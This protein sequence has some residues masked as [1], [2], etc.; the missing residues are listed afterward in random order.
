MRDLILAVRM[1]RKNLGFSL[2][3]IV[4]LALGIGANTAIFSVVKA[5]LLN[6]L[7]YYDP[8]RLVA[9]AEAEP[10]TIRPVTVDFTT[11]FDLRARSRSFESMSLYRG[12]R[13]ALVGQGDP[14]LVNG[15]RVG[16][17]Y[18]DTLGV[19][20]QLGRKFLPEDD[21]AD[22]WN[23]ILIISNG[24]WTRQFG[25][26]PNIVGRAV[27]LNE[28]TFTVAG[29]LPADFRPVPLGQSDDAKDIFAP[30]G[31]ELGKPS[32]CRGCRHLRLIAR[33]KAGVEA[34][35][36]NAE[37]NTILAGIVREHSDAYRS[38]VKV[39]LTPL[40]QQMFGQVR[41]A[42]WVLLG[43]VG[44]V[45]LIAC[46]NVA[47][48]LLARASGRAKEIALRT[49]LG[50]GRGRLIRQML[51]E[52]LVLALAGGIGGALLATLATSLVASVAPREIPRIGEV[53]VDVAVLLFGL[54]ASLLAG[55]LFG[56]APALRASRADL[57]SALADA[58][59]STGGRRTQ[60]LRNVLV[61]AEFA[62]A[63]VL[64]VGA[65][66]LG[67]SFVRLMNVDPG[68][69]P[70]NLLTL[71]TYLYGQ[72]YVQNEA[73]LN[74]VSQVFDRL[75]ATPGIESVAMV[76]TLPL[77]S[78]DRTLLHIQDQPL[79]NQNEAPSVDRYSITP[80]YF[81]V[82][83]IPLKRGRAFTGQD[84]E[85]APLLA[86]VS[87]SCA[88]RL[89]P[90][91]SA[92]GKHIQMGGRDDTKPWMTIVGVVG[93]VRQY[94]LDRAP[95]MEAY[96]PQAQNLTFSYMAV[97]RTAGDPRRMEG[98]MRDAF[99]AVDKTQ[100]VFDVAPMDTYLAASLAERSF[101]LALLALFGALALALA[102]IGIYG[103]ISYTVSFRTREIGIRMALGA[104]WSDVL[105]MVLRQGL[106]LAAAGLAT[107][108]AASLGLTRFLSSLLYEVHPTDIATTLG[109]A[110][111]LA[112]VALAG[113]YVPARRAAN[114]DPMVA[115]RFE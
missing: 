52:S 64:V 57:T 99:M 35:A 96:L 98:A 110:V 51:T 24:L 2:V 9:I 66:L 83:S 13:S 48:L 25:R 36:A 90:K 107:G 105:G 22:R 4:T 43:A 23:H 26:D 46:A 97:A 111:L 32:A 17:D 86:I 103:V 33:L 16:Y 12:W 115:L 62:L 49:A 14:V 15:L 84:R 55:V 73:S 8:D 81:R 65:G 77:T 28:S 82:M 42:L 61:T 5:V 37:L 1:L 63:F 21:R 41:T 53:K 7:P 68:F 106:T 113:S 47:N 20:M 75:R 58:G 112:L 45:L 19:K 87:E 89:F 54:A 56:L 76:S 18:F 72:R 31:Y 27:Q 92:I 3:A 38:D 104:K 39:A 93:D 102:A 44:F 11:T 85:G 79:A 95:N 94:G 80:D 71:N 78:F 60:S 6:Q 67:K 70:H 109:V 114:V 59:R 34:G 30:L 29:V 91:E 69:D 50:A 101:T 74:Y 108:V 100:P 88:R 10:A 40:R